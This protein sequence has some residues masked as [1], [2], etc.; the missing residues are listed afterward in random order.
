MKKYIAIYCVTFFSYE[1]LDL[2][3]RSIDNAI[4][5]EIVELT[6]FVADNTTHN[7]KPITYIPQHYQLEVA[8]I[9]KNYGYFAAIHLLMQEHSPF[10]Y[11]YVIVSNVDVQIEEG[12]FQSLYELKCKNNIG[13][14]AP[15]IYSTQ[16]KRDKNPQILKRYSKQK[17][18]TLRFLFKHPW[19]YTLYTQTLY[20]RK[21]IFIYTKRNIYAG[22]GSFIILTRQYFQAC[23][24]INYPIFLYGEE[25]YLAENC[26][27][28]KLNVDYNPS[29]VIY[30]SEHVSTGS[31]KN[32]VHC[33][34]N[35]EALTYILK[36][37]Y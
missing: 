17:L 21:K 23:G 27:I 4:N 1:K 8:K 26:R 24:I 28:H 5:K 34:Y 22:H 6:V 20:K 31:L 7:Q 18:Q 29:L 12:F 19:L 35:H 36:H 16:E 10:N 33:N 11:E 13:W 37:Y 30:D 15:K 3:L 14:I 9:Y 32:D 2:Y 25:L